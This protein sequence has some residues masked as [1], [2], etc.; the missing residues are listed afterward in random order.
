MKND[1]EFE[2]LI[3]QC[4]FC[5]LQKINFVIETYVKVITTLNKASNNLN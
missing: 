2:D 3:E 4:L 5:K 1:M